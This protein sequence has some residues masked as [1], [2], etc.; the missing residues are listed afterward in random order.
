MKIIKHL[1]LLI[2]LPRILR[3]AMQIIKPLLALLIGFLCI[4]L[5]SIFDSAWIVIALFGMVAILVD[6]RF[7][8]KNKGC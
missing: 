4:A 3:G 5:F 6:L 2:N 8:I 1:F 7:H